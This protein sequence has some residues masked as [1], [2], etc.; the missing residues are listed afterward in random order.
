MK[1]KEQIA[2]AQNLNLSLSGDGSEF[3]VFGR[4]IHAQFITYVF[5]SFVLRVLAAHPRCHHVRI[6]RPYNS[7]SAFVPSRNSNFARIFSRSIHV[8]SLFVSYRFHPC[9]HPDHRCNA[10]ALESTVH[11]IVLLAHFFKHPIMSMS[12][13]QDKAASPA[14]AEQQQHQGQPV[15]AIQQPGP[16]AGVGSY[17]PYYPYPM[18]PTD[19]NGHPADPNG[20]P[21]AYM[22]AFPPPPPGMIYA[23]PTAQGT[24]RPLNEYFQS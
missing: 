11:H 13:G 22:M 3:R 23:Y 4:S 7:C 12:D 5:P 10:E 2:V 18:P 6:S 17:P 15:Y 21:G 16:Y 20:A 9:I 14:T 24:Q 8:S 19:A 1:R